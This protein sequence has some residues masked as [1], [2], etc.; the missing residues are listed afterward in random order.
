[1]KQ[2]GFTL[3]EVVVALA[4][5]GIGLVVIMELFAGG[6][7]L[8]RTSEEYTQAVSYA[9]MKMEEIALA[10][11]MQEGTEEGEFDK[12]FRWQVAVQKVDL[13]PGDKGAEFKPPVEFY[14]VHLKVLWKSGLKERMTEIESY[15]T[16]KVQEVEEKSPK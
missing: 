2:R 6:L 7:R 16:V 15:K 4:I 1:M 9:R 8:E 13:L 10:E 11:S 5:L 3:V 14:Q 12:D